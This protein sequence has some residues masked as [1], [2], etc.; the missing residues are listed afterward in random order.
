MPRPASKNLSPELLLFCQLW[1]L[2][3]GTRAVVD[4]WMESRGKKGEKPTPGDYV[5]ASKALRRKTVKDFI[6]ILKVSDAFEQLRE[7]RKRIEAARKRME[8]NAKMLENF[9]A[10]RTQAIAFWSQ[11]LLIGTPQIVDDNGR[12]DPAFA[13]MVETYKRRA[14]GS[15][16][17]SIP[18]KDSATKYLGALLNWNAQS[19]EIQVPASL[20]VSAK[21]WREC[22]NTD[23]NPALPAAPEPDRNWGDSR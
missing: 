12:V 16:E 15:W 20:E 14:D 18:S 4:V 22:R 7:T 5:N 8:E 9:A 21:P 23:E 11:V 13:H 6:E 2:A 3:E 10:T 19:T 1:A 17:V